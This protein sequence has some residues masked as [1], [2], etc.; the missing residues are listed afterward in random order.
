[1]SKQAAGKHVDELVRLGYVE[2]RPHA[3][4]GRAV[5]VTFTTEGERLLRDIVATIRS[6]ERSYADAI[7]AREFE[8]LAG[9]VAKLRRA[10]ADIG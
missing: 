5:L 8:R 1:M 7:G 10:V 2:R 4:D 6:I 9:L 3:D